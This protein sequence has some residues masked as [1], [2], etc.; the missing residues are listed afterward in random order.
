MTAPAEPPLTVRD[1]RQTHWGWFDY[2]LLD[3]YGARIGPAGIAVYIALCRY[4]RSSTQQ[5]WPSY[6]TLAGATGLSRRHVIRTIAALATAGLISVA[7]RTTGATREADSHLYT[8]LPLPGGSDTMSPPGVTTSPGGDTTSP[9][10]VTPCHQGGDT[11]SPEQYG[12]NKTIGTR[13]RERAPATPPPPAHLN[14]APN[15]DDAAWLAR[16]VAAHSLPAHAVDPAEETES[17]QDAIAS[18]KRP[19]PADA[20]ADWRLW[21]RRA[22]KWALAHPKEVPPYGSTTPRPPTAGDQPQPGDPDRDA[23][24]L[25]A[26]L[27]A[28]AAEFRRVLDPPARRPPGPPDLPR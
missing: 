7:P 25:A 5:A 1:N 20:R 8:L 12:G 21:L 19:I 16:L 2:A 9:P 28:L 27:D 24:A 17:W 3:V 26:Q 6:A 4:A 13:G 22:V 10:V 23:A 14:F 15:A 18:G 11:M